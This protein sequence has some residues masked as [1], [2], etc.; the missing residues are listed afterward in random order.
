M[1]KPSASVNLNSYKDLMT[2][3]SPILPNQCVPTSPNTPHPFI[4]YYAYIMYSM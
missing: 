1:R 2:L 3:P 4:A